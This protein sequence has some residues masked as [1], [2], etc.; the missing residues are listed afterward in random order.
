M[1]AAFIDKVGL[2]MKDASQQD[3]TTVSDRNGDK[4]SSEAAGV[5]AWKI[6]LDGNEGALDV[7]LY[8]DTACAQRLQALT[9]SVLSVMLEQ[10]HQQK[11]NHQE[12]MKARQLASHQLPGSAGETVAGKLKDISTP[13]SRQ[14][15]H[16]VLSAKD[17]CLPGQELFCARRQYSMGFAGVCLAGDCRA[18]PASFFNEQQCTA[19]CTCQVCGKG[20]SSLQ[21]PQ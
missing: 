16:R 12:R 2:G 18:C 19:Q 5:C 15:F 1:R 11:R 14:F 17:F 10:Q 7:K 4:L 9:L 21:V 20:R 6:I 13:P 3:Q 8:Q